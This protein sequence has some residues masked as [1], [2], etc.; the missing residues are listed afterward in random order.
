[1][2]ICL[3]GAFRVNPSLRPLAVGKGG[4]WVGERWDFR[5]NIDTKG[6]LLSGQEIAI[7]R[8]VRWLFQFVMFLEEELTRYLF[9]YLLAYLLMY[10]CMYVCTYVCI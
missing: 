1:M 2:F 7:A 5:H 4:G 9:I 3:M 10:V 8:K 6:V